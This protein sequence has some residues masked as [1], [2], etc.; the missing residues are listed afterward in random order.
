MN[1]SRH[2]AVLALCLLVVGCS[3]KHSPDSKGGP[4]A[5]KARPAVTLQLF[6]PEAS[7]G[8]DRV[9][10]REIPVISWKVRYRLTGNPDP[11][12]WYMVTAD[13]GSA[14]GIEYI[15]GKDLKPE[16][17]IEGKAGYRGDI[18]ESIKIQVQR[19]KGHQKGVFD[20]EPVGGPVT[21][22]VNRRPNP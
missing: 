7:A 4:S 15:E 17:V 13:P 8:I 6:E 18:P 9:G 3:Q 19:S 22:P 11:A 20:N 14:V 5:A 12:E 10:G 16:G 2:S 1:P 21:C